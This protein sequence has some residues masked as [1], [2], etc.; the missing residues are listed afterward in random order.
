MARPALMG[1]DLGT[2]AVKVGIFDAQ[3]GEPLGVARSEYTP[4][5][6]RAGWMEL[7]ARE[8]WRAAAEATRAAHRQAGAPQVAGIGL[9]SQG[10]TLVPLDGALRPLRPAIVWLDTRAEEQA[11][12]LNELLP[13][14]DLRRHRGAAAINAIDSAPKLLW[15]REHEPETWAATRHV[16]MLPDYLG[17]L[18]TGELR[19]DLSNAGS[20]ALVDRVTDDWWDAGLEAVGLPREW[21]SPLGHAGEA[22][23]LLSESAARELG[24]GAA[25]PVALGCNDQLAGAVGAGNVEPGL[26]SGTAGTAM[27]IVTTLR[28]LPE[29]MPAGLLMGRHAVPGLCFLLTYAKTSGVLLTW[30]RDLLGGGDYEALLAEAAGAPVG[31]DGLVC[32][33]HFSGTATPTFRS[34]VRGGF[35]GLTLG[36]GRAHLLRAAAEAVCC[37]ARDALALAADAAS[38]AGSP[39]CGATNEGAPRGAPI[40]ELRML[41]GAARSDWWMQMMADVVRLPIAVPA[42][43]D[44]AVLGAAVFGGVAAGLL[45]SI[46]EGGR[47]FY[48]P[49]RRFTPDSDLAPAYDAAWSAYRDAMERL[50]PGALGEACLPRRPADAARNPLRPGT[51]L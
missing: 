13:A 26:A 30:L 21:L 29:P 18:M 3:T 24:L 15:L 47:R 32:L 49:E 37:C 25:V 44:A 10:Q 50:W 6:P 8:Y 41:G 16:V 34:E 27:A 19:L 48:R 1:L 9:S 45:G 43:A 35:V 7:D 14:E 4:T 22:I 33:P 12:R 17:L 46:E 20:M 11:R 28:A 23:G 51:H 36:H 5:S 39:T 38:R 2:T 40:R 31:C 42:C